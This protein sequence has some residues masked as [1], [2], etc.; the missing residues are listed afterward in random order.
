[1]LVLLSSL[2]V[3]LVLG[4]VEFWLL[5]AGF[6]LLLPGAA[7]PGWIIGLGERLP[8]VLRSL[9]SCLG[10]DFELH[11]LPPGT[12]ERCLPQPVG[13]LGRFDACWTPGCV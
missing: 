1:M 8:T 10:A 12:T 7:I 4:A 2:A 13:W 5:S 6:L 9:G 3:G 11:L